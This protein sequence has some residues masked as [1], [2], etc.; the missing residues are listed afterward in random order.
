MEL[1]AE[2]LVTWQWT[3]RECGGGTEARNGAGAFGVKNAF[4]SCEVAILLTILIPFF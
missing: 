4:C 3:Y 1:Q 2:E